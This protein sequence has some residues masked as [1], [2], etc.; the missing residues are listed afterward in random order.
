MKNFKP[1][2]LLIVPFMLIGCSGGSQTNSD[3]GVISSDGSIT[4]ESSSEEEIIS[5]GDVSSDMEGIIPNEKGK[6]RYN[7]EAHFN[8]NY[9]AQSATVFNDDL[10]ML[11][12]VTSVAANSES[13]TRD[14]YTAMGYKH[15]KAAFPNPTEDTIGYALA[16]KAAKDFDLYSVSV[17]GFNYGEEWANNVTIGKE[18]NHQGFEARAKEIYNELDKFI[19]DY[20]TTKPVKIWLTGYSRGGGVSNVLASLLMNEESKIKTTKDDLFVYTFEAP[21]GLSEEN[22][23]A[24][25][26]VF[27]LINDGDLVTMIAPEVYGLFRCGTDVIINEDKDVGALLKEFDDGLTI[28]E[29]VPIEDSYDNQKQYNQFVLNILSTDTGDEGTT[30][31]TREKYVDN[32]EGSFAYFIGLYFTLPQSTIDKVI[33]QVKTMDSSSA[34]GLINSEDGFYNLVKPILDED[35]ISYDDAKLQSACG[36][37]NKLA[38]AEMML[39]FLLYA[40][41]GFMNNLKRSIYMHSIES[42]YVLIK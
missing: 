31:H 14:Y 24:Y 21:R 37:L 10:K 2:L 20:T 39:I 41:E 19:T 8:D 9:F 27:N 6:K 22:A 3:G 13:K 5:E 34:M 16:H 38:K 32:Y 15:I 42:V 11:S 4:S 35:N 12:F 7:V 25:E 1:L 17:R 36:A 30:L 29:F 23:V 26:N 18:G 40:N 33:N 28:P